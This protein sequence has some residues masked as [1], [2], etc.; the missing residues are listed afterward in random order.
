MRD[1]LTHTLT[2]DDGTEVSA[3]F[4]LRIAEHSVAAYRDAPKLAEEHYL[5][6][7]STDLSDDTDGYVARLTESF[8]RPVGPDFYQ[9]SLDI[10]RKYGMSVEECR[11]IQDDP[12][13]SV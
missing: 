11:W 5:K 1:T 6:Y 12:L 9:K 10:I 8:R 13:V 3:E 2:L 4:M 7:V